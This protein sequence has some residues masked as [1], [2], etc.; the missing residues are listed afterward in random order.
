MILTVLRRKLKVSTCIAL[1]FKILN[2][3]YHPVLNDRTSFVL[4]LTKI[5]VL[6]LSRGGSNVD[7]HRDT[8]ALLLAA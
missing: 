1:G 3:G 4:L 7:G 5:F 8:D 2:I 6:I